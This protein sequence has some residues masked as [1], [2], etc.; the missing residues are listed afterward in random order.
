MFKSAQLLLF[1]LSLLHNF[2]V[3][4]LILIAIISA[5]HC[6]KRYTVIGRQQHTYHA[7]NIRILITICLVILPIIRAY[8]ILTK[9]TI[10]LVHNEV[11]DYNT[12]AP[13]NLNT[14][15]LKSINPT[16]DGINIIS[17]IHGELN[18]TAGLDKSLFSLESSINDITTT[19]IAP[20]I[21]DYEP[22]LSKINDKFTS[23]KPV[24]YLVAGT[25]GL[26]WVVHLFFI[27]SLKRGRR[28]PN[29]RGPILIRALILLL[30]VISVLLLR[31]H[32]NNP[33]KD[34]V[35]PN[36]SLGFSISV[37]TSLILYI[38]TLIPGPGRLEHMRTP[39]RNIAVSF[40]WSLSLN[41]LVQQFILFLVLL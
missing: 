19:A 16:L 35:L 41:Y 38:I 3:P 11:Q 34:D 40:C 5:Y 20:Y 31:S 1:L 7:I 27:L 30:I 23:A 24:D 12:L 10:P 22:I 29:P 9:T 39:S 15:P 36:L 26:A 14:S 2:Q 33:P 13:Q 21:S 18:R 4:V 25:E 17:G 32:V 8:I 6:G 28:G 37:V